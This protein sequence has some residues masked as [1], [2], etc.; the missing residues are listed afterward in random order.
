MKHAVKKHK[1]S[2]LAHYR[3]VFANAVRHA[4]G[5]PNFKQA[6][7]AYIKKHHKKTA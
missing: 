3:Q 2:K 4:K 6:V 7:A 1:S 5:K